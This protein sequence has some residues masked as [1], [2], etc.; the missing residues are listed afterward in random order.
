M[1]GVGISG[2]AEC[3][4]PSEGDENDDLDTVISASVVEFDKDGVLAHVKHS[5]SPNLRDPVW[6]VIHVLESPFVSVSRCDVEATKRHVCLLC[7]Q[8]AASRKRSAT[9]WKHGL[10]KMSNASNAKSHLT[11]THKGHPLAAAL[12]TQAVAN[13][14]QTIKRNATELAVHLGKRKSELEATLKPQPMKKSS[15]LAMF[16][17]SHKLVNTVIA[18]WLIVDGHP[19]NMVTTSAF[20]EAMVVATGDSNLTIISRTSFNSALDA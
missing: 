16:C 2:D 11:R 1:L 17:P 15:I 3:E 5:Q 6:S 14:E 18:K 7:T 19:F 9:H 4:N 8:A 12:A 13:A 10:Y 20:K